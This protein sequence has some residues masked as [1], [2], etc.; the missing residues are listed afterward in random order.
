MKLV[1]EILLVKKE[2][3]GE[4]LSFRGLHL[5]CSKKVLRIMATTA[6]ETAASAGDYVQPPQMVQV[7]A[8]ER[9]RVFRVLMSN[10]FFLGF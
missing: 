1:F 2:L 9:E 10:L 6:P 5:D 7:S 3:L 4:Y 8:G